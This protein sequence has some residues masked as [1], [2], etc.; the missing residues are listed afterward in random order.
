M[1]HCT[2]LIIHIFIIHQNGRAGEK[3]RAA[4]RGRWHGRLPHFIHAHLQSRF[5]KVRVEVCMK[6]QRTLPAVMP[7]IVITPW[8]DLWGFTRSTF[9]DQVAFI[10]G[11]GSGIGLRIAEIFMRWEDHPLVS[12]TL[13]DLAVILLYLAVAVLEY[14]QTLC[15]YYYSLTVECVSLMVCAYVHFKPSSFVI[16]RF[17]LPSL[18]LRDKVEINQS[19]TDSCGRNVWSFL[20]TSNTNSLSFHMWMSC[21]SR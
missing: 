17:R 8:S 7:A 2:E 13:P 19:T 9:R 4:A 15:H 21:C 1:P 6:M 12:L 16:W 11:G 20:Q 10:T 14:T 3:R 18:W 5:T